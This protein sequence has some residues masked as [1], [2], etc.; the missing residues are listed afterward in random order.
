MN[1]QHMFATAQATAQKRAAAFQ[2]SLQGHDP[3]NFQVPVRPSFTHLTPLSKDAPG[4][5]P[6]SQDEAARVKRWIDN[7]VEHEV[8]YAT[9]SKASTARLVALA[10]AQATDMPQD[11]IGPYA[12]VPDSEARKFTGVFTDDHIRAR[13]A[14]KRGKLRATLGWLPPPSNQPQQPARGR[15]GYQQQQQMQGSLLHG[16]E[17]DW[18]A[19]HREL[20]NIAQ[21][22]EILIPVRVDSE[23][24]GVKI[25]D[26]FTWNL[27]GTVDAL[28]A[29]EAPANQCT[30]T[31]ASSRVFVSHLLADMHIPPSLQT[32]FFQDIVKQIDDQLSEPPAA[33]FY[34][35]VHST[36]RSDHAKAVDE[37]DSWHVFEAAPLTTE[38]LVHA[39]ADN[40]K[41]EELRILVKLDITLDTLNLT[42]T[43]EWDLS[44][45]H[46]NPENFAETLCVDLGLPGEF[47][48]AV[49]HSIREQVEA[50]IK[51][52][53]LVSHSLG[54][55][56]TNDE[57]KSAFLPPLTAPS[58]VRSLHM[59][60]DYTPELNT[61]SVDDQ[62]R[63]LA[64]RERESRR[65]RRNTRGR[66][67]VNLPDREPLKTV[68]SLVPRPGGKP[69][70]MV[71]AQP[72]QNNDD[73]DDEDAYIDPEEKEE[74]KKPRLSEFDVARPYKIPVCRPWF[75][76][77][78]FNC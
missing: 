50:H 42:D 12:D 25:R 17:P 28:G 21:E 1:N 7:D 38:D 78:V 40:G 59:V 5:P 27:K 77:R 26:V 74:S 15:N 29:H 44:D 41:H 11:W 4:L 22:P 48:T 43:I 75:H 18:E 34:D 69:P 56:I 51:S 46:N 53:S 35:A 66:Q 13:A 67:R 3:A 2:A 58:A 10:Q 37:D 57:L 72:V 33:A 71:Q 14:G 9:A 65:K 70:V 23:H 39:S 73:D 6:I 61:L 24:D 55:P 19:K 49:A 45:P 20:Q 30:D 16:S 63:Q 47:I 64:Q 31:T 62:E 60:T 54:M 68:R 36:F 8:R 32:T 52:L 76:I